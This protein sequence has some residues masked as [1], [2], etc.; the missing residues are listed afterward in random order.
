MSTILILPFIHYA[1]L[2]CGEISVLPDYFK[3]CFQLKFG[4][5]KKTNLLT[6]HGNY[7]KIYISTLYRTTY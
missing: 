7:S 3:L 4:L 5:R 1:A 2:N 6:V